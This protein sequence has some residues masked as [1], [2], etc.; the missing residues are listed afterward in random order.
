MDHIREA[1]RQV[2][3]GIDFDAPEKLLS[4]VKPPDATRVPPGMPYSLATNVAHTDIWNSV[5]LAALEGEPKVN[6]FPDFP[7]I[8]EEE[9]PAVRDS[10]LMNLRKAYKISLGE[11]FTHEMK[12]DDSACRHLLKI[13]VHTTYHIGQFALL[14]RTLALQKKAARQA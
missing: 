13:A 14:K 5:W 12:S 9:W 8:A 10:F 2:I 6:P 11:P 1:L 4:R 7:I 3:E